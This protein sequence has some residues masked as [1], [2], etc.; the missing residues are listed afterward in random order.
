[1][2]KAIAIGL[3]LLSSAALHAQPKPPENI[4]PGLYASVSKGV[5]ACCVGP[6]AGRSKEL[7]PMTELLQ[8]FLLGSVPLGPD[9]VLFQSDVA[10]ALIR[11][12]DRAVVSEMQWWVRHNDSRETHV[13]AAWI[14]T[15]YGDSKAVDEVMAEARDTSATLRGGVGRTLSVQQQIDEDRAYAVRMLGTIGDRRAVPLLCKLLK[16]T[17]LAASA[18]VSLGEIGDP[19]ALPAL[20]QA[21]STRSQ[22]ALVHEAALQAI[23]K[24]RARHP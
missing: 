14:L 3:T 19:A 5:R 1:M 12:G 21:L 6:V 24:I 18:A 10:E 9:V 23:G 13:N 4:P 22:A 7:P 20:R 2:R 11:S 15:R 16:D 8:A 17:A